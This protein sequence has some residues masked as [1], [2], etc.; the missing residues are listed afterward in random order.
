MTP[1]LTG[2][3]ELTVE[4]VE[5]VLRGRATCVVFDE[6]GETYPLPKKEAALPAMRRKRIR[7]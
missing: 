1:R 4:E 7:P 5:R 2:D 3:E 6:R